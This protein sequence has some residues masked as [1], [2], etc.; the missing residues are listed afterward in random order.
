MNWILS[1]GKP[2]NLLIKSVLLSA[3]VLKTTTSPLY[4]LFDNI[5]PLKIG[6]L[7]GNEWLL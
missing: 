2:I 3:G 6:G 1:P 4:G 5:L 7:K